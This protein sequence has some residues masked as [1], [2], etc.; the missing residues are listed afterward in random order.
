MSALYGMSK[1]VHQCCLFQD[2]SYERIPVCLACQQAASS[3]DPLPPLPPPE[4]PPQ[5][6]DDIEE[7]PPE[8]GVEL[9][10]LPED[11]FSQKLQETG[12]MPC[13]LHG[14]DHLSRDP[15]L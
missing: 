5:G 9:D 11:Y 13:Q 2:H 10:L 7:K 8:K 14:M 12:S 4:S 6:E 3:T 1:T 15:G